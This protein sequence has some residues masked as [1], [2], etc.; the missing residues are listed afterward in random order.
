MAA[1]ALLFVK[2]GRNVYTI[3][4]LGVCVLLSKAFIDYSTSGLENPLSHF[5]LIIAVLFAMAAVENTNRRLTAFLLACSALYLNRPDIILLV[6]PLFILV[7][8]RHV[9][10]KSRIVGPM[11]VAI[12]PPLLWTLFALFYYGFPF[13]NTAYAKLGTGIPFT[14]MVMQGIRYLLHSIDKDPITIF[15]IFAGVATGFLRSTL[16]KSLATGITFY[17]LYVISIGGDFMAG[18]FFAA[19]FLLSLVILARELSLKHII[20]LFL[21]IVV[22]GIMGVGFYA[23]I[24]SGSSYHNRAIGPDGIAD[25]R[26]YYFQYT[27]LLN[28]RRGTLTAPRMAGFKTNSSYNI[29]RSRV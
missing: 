4:L 16:S 1:I 28:A 12:V 26:G 10:D 29:W 13:P 6:F 23:N 25:E 5:L 11:A 7:L 8:F 27:G 2:F 20:S 22:C 3:I 21:P 18:R 24:V 17:I 9:Q 19:P 15:I 14:A